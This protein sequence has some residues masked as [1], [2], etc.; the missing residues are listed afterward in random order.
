MLGDFKRALDDAVIESG[1][2]H[3]DQMTQLLSHT[4][5]MDGFAKVIFDLLRLAGRQHGN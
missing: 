3:N 1:D 4:K 5:K 2:A